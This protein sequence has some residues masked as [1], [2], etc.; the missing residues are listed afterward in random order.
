MAAKDKYHFHF[1]TSLENDGWSIT[2]DPYILEAGETEYEIDI[3]AEKLIG[4]ERDGQKIAV[5]LKSF[6]GESVAYDFHEAL[7]QYLEY[8]IGLQIQE[9]DR[10]VFLAVSVDRFER[11]KKLTLPRLALEQFHVSVI[12]FDINSKTI[13]QWIK[14]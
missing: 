12:V 13:V 3:G 10:E 5:E 14:N 9:P 2:H 7:G 4:A 6:L 8:R 1:R 11:I